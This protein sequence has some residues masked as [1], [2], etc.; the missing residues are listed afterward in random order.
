VSAKT[1]SGVEDMFINCSRQVMLIMQMGGQFLSNM[2][3]SI[4]GVKA[5][6]EQYNDSND[7]M[8][9][10]SRGA[11]ILRDPVLNKGTQ[12]S[13]IERDELSLRG[14]IPVRQCNIGMQITRNM[15]RLRMRDTDLSRFMDLQAIFDRN[16]TLYYRLLV[17]NLEE[18]HRIVF[19]PTVGDV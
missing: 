8:L 6:S 15:E 12:F 5:A 13:E 18:L 14:L 17:E 3:S 16:E 7:I 9:V 2:S 19:I 11:N 1:G 10:S 4:V